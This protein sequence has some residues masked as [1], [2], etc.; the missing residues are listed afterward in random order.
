[1]STAPRLPA[2]DS[3][4]KIEKSLSQ[5]GEFVKKCQACTLTLL[6]MK[7]RGKKIVAPD[8]GSERLRI[9]GCGG[10]ELGV[11][12]NDIVRMHEIEI[13][14][15]GSIFQQRSAALDSNLVPA[16]MRHFERGRIREADNLAA[17]DI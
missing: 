13:C 17:K 11:I 14:V 2:G 3:N 10:G 7:L 6:R 12:G 4:Q 1:M 5:G 8:Y 9:I 15:V 16:H